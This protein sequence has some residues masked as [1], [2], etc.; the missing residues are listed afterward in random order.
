M[1]GRSIS[2]Q[3]SGSASKLENTVS[4]IMRRTSQISARDLIWNGAQRISPMTLKTTPLE[5]YHE[6]T[7]WH[8]I[9]KHEAMSSDLEF[10]L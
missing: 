1:C 5:E 10:V 4:D 6:S 9:R 2:G 7:P 3:L 8:S